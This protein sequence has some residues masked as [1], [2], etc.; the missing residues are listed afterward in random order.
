MRKFFVCIVVACL[1][2][3]G[4]SV[5]GAEF[6]VGETCSNQTEELNAENSYQTN[7]T[8]YASQPASVTDIRLKGSSFAKKN[9]VAQTSTPGIYQEKREVLLWENSKGWIEWNVNIPNDG[10]YNMGLVYQPLD[11]T[12]TDI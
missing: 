4:L 9:E 5:S 7:R 3:S 10:I 12:G 6:A 1:M 2:L 11:G 8:Q